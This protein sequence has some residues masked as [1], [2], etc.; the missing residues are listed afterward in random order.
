MLVF[1]CACLFLFVILFLF[2]PVFVALFLYL[3]ALLMC[4]IVC[5]SVCVC[6]CACFYTMKWMEIAVHPTPKFT[7]GVGRVLVFGARENNGKHPFRGFPCFEISPHER[8]KM[9]WHC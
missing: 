3:L 6:A 1:V 5:V 7:A 4:L 8:L 2:L 9:G